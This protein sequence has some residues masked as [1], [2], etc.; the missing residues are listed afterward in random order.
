VDAE[1]EAVEARLEAGTLARLKD[2]MTR[3]ALDD[4]LAAGA[5][6]AA[7]ARLALAE[8]SLSADRP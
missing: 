3:S 1:L 5:A 6:L 2:S 7:H 4:A 8:A